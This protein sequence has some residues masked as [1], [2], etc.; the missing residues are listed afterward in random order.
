MR[1]ISLP[2]LVSVLLLAGAAG[3]AQPPAVL[4]LVSANAD[5]VAG[6]G[7]SQAPSLSAD[8]R[9]VVFESRARLVRGD[10]DDR[11]DVY[12]RD[13]TGRTV[14]LTPG[15][16]GD[17]RRPSLS[18]DGRYVAFDSTP[19]DVAGGPVVV[20]CDRDPDGDGVLDEPAP[21][22]APDLRCVRIAEPAAGFG[23]TAPSL[24]RDA[25]TLVWTRQPAASDPFV[26]VVELGRDQDGVL[27]EL[28]PATALQPTHPDYQLV[29]GVNAPA[30]VSAD[31]TTVVFPVVLC[32]LYC[33]SSFAGT[34]P[35][36]L[37][38]ARQAQRSA[39]Y[40]ATLHPLRMSLV[41]FDAT[42]PVVSADGTTIAYARDGRVLVA[43][44]SGVRDVG[45]GAVPAVSG[46][47]RYLVY[48][49]P[50]VVARD[51]V[52]DRAEPVAATG[53]GGVPALSGDGAVVA[54][55]STTAL[56]PAD[57]NDEL[58]DVYRR[59]FAPTLAGTPLDFGPVRPGE[60]VTT[61]LTLRHNGFGPLSVI[62][63]TTEGEGFSV[64]PVENCT[65]TTLHAGDECVVSV[66]FAADGAGVRE[67]MLVVATST[68]PV[69]VPVRGEAVP[70]AV[71]ALRVSPTALVFP[72]ETLATTSS[73]PLPVA[74]VN[75]G[76]APVTITGIDPFPVPGAADFSASGCAGAVLAVG[77]RCEVSVVATPRGGGP[78]TG[79]LV[80]TSTASPEPL[81]VALSATG[82]LPRV[83][84]SPSVAL[85]GQVV[86]LS[87]ENFPPGRP[88]VVTGAATPAGPV[89]ADSSGRFS[90]SLLILGRVPTGVAGA[91]TASVDGTDVSESAPLLVVAGT[92]QPPGFL[93][94]R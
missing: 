35:L 10:T 82:A 20:V 54:F 36:S 49:T 6:D 2:L 68:G 74:L 57:G 72:G 46:D 45:P 29:L 93:G 7:P 66:R 83:S 1:L 15:P 42:A 58:P 44:P 61:A 32:P 52:S 73:P 22:G 40:S 18:P 31:G 39:V 59:T 85:R 4:D 63:T 24:S 51:L 28:A 53:P 23:D 43:S 14:L 11:W 3:S 34:R 91:V 37:S 77:E 21:S 5:G 78:R 80:V 27:R 92:Y 19:A 9:E 50:D 65:G 70:E 47:G 41:D 67:G 62:G 81:V 71:P 55:D 56:V 69:R 12:L 16:D 94:R 86:E 87:G 90:A 48:R 38:G 8:G 26:M 25:K 17:G 64:F 13:R 30:R 33:G 89:S 75:S 76:T 88:V 79:A 84:V 60:S